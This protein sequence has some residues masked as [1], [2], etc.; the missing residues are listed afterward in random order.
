MNLK[1]GFLN[2][3]F[4]FTKPNPTSEYLILLQQELQKVN[5][6]SFQTAY[7]V[8]LDVPEKIMQLFSSD[9]AKAMHAS[10][11]LWCGLCHQYSGVS[12]A[13]LPAFPFL[14][15]GLNCFDD[16]LKIE[17]LDI[18]CGFAICTQDNP[19]DYSVL[20]RQTLLTELPRFQAL[21]H[22]DNA[23]IAWWGRRIC[24]ALLIQVLITEDDLKNEIAQVVTCIGNQGVLFDV[25]FE[26]DKGKTK[27][28]QLEIA[29]EILLHLP[30][31]VT[32]HISKSITCDNFESII[33]ELEIKLPEIKLFISI[34]FNTTCVVVFRRE[35]EDIFHFEGIL[36]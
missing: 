2:K 18:L 12:S 32:E 27:N 21:T 28:S 31:W 14:L 13:A 22:H 9:H 35:E 6:S 23:E 5:W 8:A 19:Y 30:Q 29:Y 10:H 3:L 17:L 34:S 15:K 16:E 25:A 1:R 7:G 24:K 33:E 11:E 36:L 26:F 4:T 20:L